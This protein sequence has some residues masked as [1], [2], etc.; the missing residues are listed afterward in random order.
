MKLLILVMQILII[1]GVGWLGL[2]T[3]SLLLPPKSGRWSKGL[4]LLF[5]AA[6]TGMVIFFGDLG[7]LPPTLLIFCLCSWR[8]CR[9]TVWQKITVVLLF[10][11]FAFSLSAIFDNFIMRYLSLYDFWFLPGMFR[12]LG[13][14]LLYLFLRHHAPR[15]DYSLSPRLW[16]MLVLVAIPPFGSVTGIV[17]LSNQE[18]GSDMA[19]M[20]VYLLILVLALCSFAAILKLI[21]VLANYQQLE[22]RQTLFEMEKRY[23][24][25][26]EKQNDGMRRLR[27]DITNHL[28]TLLALGVNER[29]AYLTKLLATKALT[30]TTRYCQDP[31]LNA[32]L[33]VKQAEMAALNITFRYS[34]DIPAPLKME[35]VDVSTIFTNALDNAR[36]YCAHLPDRQR[37]VH[38]E[39]RLKGGMFTVRLTN[40]YNGPELA[41]QPNELP[42][43]TKDDT[44]SHGLG[45]K[46]ILA[47]TWQYQGQLEITT[48][49][50]QFILFLY[51]S[52]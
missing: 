4:L 1:F 16:K 44:V 26:L 14:G 19:V 42:S 22:Q 5:F 47:V 29:T 40:P 9:G 2:R 28:Q 33:N 24:R 45:L 3:F 11:S 48:K 6:F 23:Y 34:L 49:D 43:T 8:L 17:L 18:V 46:S 13:W 37:F 30:A 20:R 51:V 32:I 25:T 15:P 12:G 39:A 10:A 36:E 35:P 52:L 27:H 31:T 21:A 50:R 38:L 7:N 41:L